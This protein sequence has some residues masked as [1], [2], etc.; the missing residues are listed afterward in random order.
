MNSPSDKPA[1]KPIFIIVAIVIIL[2]I[3]MAGIIFY[4]AVWRVPDNREEVQKIENE[5]I[6]KI[7][8]GNAIPKDDNA[9]FTYYDAVEKFESYRV[10][11]IHNP[12]LNPSSID[13]MG[14]TN[15]NIDAVKKYIQDNKEILKLSAKAYKQKDFQVPRDYKMGAD[16]KTP[17]LLAVRSFVFL[18]A[19]NGDLL[20]KEG[21]YKEAAEL[22]M[23]GLHL[24]VGVGRNGVLIMGMINIALE[25]IVFKHLIAFLSNYDVDA[26]TCRYLI[27]EISRWEK[28]RSSFTDFMDN[29]AVFIH[30]TIEMLKTGK[31][32]SNRQM[33]AVAEVRW[34]MDREE[35][36]Y[37]NQY[38][39]DRS[40]VT[41]DYKKACEA[42][43]DDID[44]ALPKFTILPRILYPNYK[45]AYK[46]NVLSKMEYGGILL[47]A[48]LKLY[49]KEKGKYPESLSELVPDYLKEIPK[50]PYS[51]D[52]KF[53]YKKDGENVQLYTI[54]PDMKDGGGKAGVLHR[55]LE[56]MGD[57]IFYNSIVKSQKEK[58]K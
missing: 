12:D 42:L 54:G 9:W 29:E 55:D 58:I 23:Q 52:G 5:T 1:K 27:N 15:E 38:L 3:I 33:Q 43:P 53:V 34:F 44:A 51:P 13:S 50:D 49:R 56:S 36:I 47:A 20:A 10:N 22:Y 45:R 35:R 31:M 21:K 26:D 8:K 46:Q 30:Y 7:E 19:L 11:K 4:L 16:E 48:G 28:T 24:G 2:I 18:L 37:E 41:I 39:K 57:I 14:L 40:I 32:S 25:S 6:E 17:N